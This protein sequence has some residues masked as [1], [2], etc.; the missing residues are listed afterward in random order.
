MKNTIRILLVTI[1]ACLVGTYQIYSLTN[2]DKETDPSGIPTE[3][4]NA[5]FAGG[6]F[7]CTESDFEKVP[8][9]LEVI[10]G[11][12]GGHVPNPTY[13]Q[14]SSGVSGH[15]ETV[16]VIYDPATITYEQ[17]LEIFWRHVDPTDGGGQFVDRGSQY[18]SV[19][20]YSND[21]E[22]KLA[23]TSKQKLASSGKFSKP[24]ATDI[25]ALGTFYPAEE[26][27]QNF[28]K[29][30]PVRYKS[31]RSSSGRDQFLK[32]TW[33]ASADM[34]DNMN[35]P[36][37]TNNTLSQKEHTYMRPDDATLR[38]QLTP[39]QYNVVRKNGT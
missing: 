12:T 32:K 17:L 26:Y 35:M 39:L 8:G 6:C 30:D 24:I 19:I 16:K 9:V 25:L 36:N 15:V 18:R 22:Q 14:V 1:I 2:A 21:V 28:Y 4:S 38:V 11:Y 31:Y 23:E 5:F 37:K 29:K 34:S 3:T 13:K 7:W 10:S 27:H 20:F 33:P